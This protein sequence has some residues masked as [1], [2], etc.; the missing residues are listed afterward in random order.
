VSDEPEDDILDDPPSDLDR[1]DDLLELC[2][3][4]PS[5]C[6]PPAFARAFV[7][8]HCCGGAANSV[9]LALW[10]AKANTQHPQHRREPEN[11]VNV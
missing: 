11:I 8:V 7:T 6:R 3:A 9:G 2:A 1:F 10:C 4:P 5:L